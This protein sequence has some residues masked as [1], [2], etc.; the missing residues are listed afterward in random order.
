MEIEYI[1]EVSEMDYPPNGEFDSGDGEADREQVASILEQ[2]NS[3]NLWAWCCVKVI[4]QVEYGGQVFKGEAHLGAC[5][6]ENEKGFKADVYYGDMCREALEDLKHGLANASHT[7]KLAERL[8]LLS[9]MEDW[10]AQ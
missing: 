6:Y 3:G 4:A 5:S 8:L 1:I 2:L 7:G 10:M 9:K